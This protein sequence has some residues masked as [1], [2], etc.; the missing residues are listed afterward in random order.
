MK[1]SIFSFAVNDKFPIDIAHRQFK[2]FMKEEFEYILF[3]DAFDP[4]MEKNIDVIA[5]F[6]NIKC[7]RVPQSIHK[8]NNPSECYASTLNWAVREYAIQNKCNIIVLM[9]TDVFPV[10]DVSISNILGDSVIASTAEFRILGEK[11]ISYFYPAFTIIDMNKLSNPLEL[12]FGL[13]TGLDAG[14]KTRH[15]IE[16]YPNDVKFI[17]NHQI[18]YFIRTLGTESIAEYYKTDL[19]ICRSHGLSAGW[20]ADG[21]LH[22]MAGSQW[23]AGDNSNF[24]QGHIKRMEL[25]LKYFY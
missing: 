7:V 3:N 5:K 24:A 25:F 6:N 16:K 11:G 1:I 19:E 12:D 8:A 2:K 20:I 15:F 22:Y 23:N 4:K 10:C 18:T 14:G 21:F 13:D 17:P 9:H